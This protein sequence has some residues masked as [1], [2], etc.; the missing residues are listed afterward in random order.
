MSKTPVVILDA[1]NSII[2]ARSATNEKSFRHGLY[3]L[4]DAEFSA[5]IQRAQ[6]EIPAG[7]IRVNG[8]AYAFGEDAERHGTVTRPRGAARYTHE[9]YGTLAAVALAQL[10]PSANGSVN[11]FGSHP[12]GDIAYNKDL[13]KAAIG[14]YHVEIGQAE[15]WYEVCGATTFDEPL[16][17]LMNR[18][19]T[20][21]G[22]YN[23]RWQFNGGDTL[24]IDIGGF[25][26]DLIA[27]KASGKLDYSIAIS[28]ELGIQEA[29]RN[30]ERAV[31]A[32]YHKLFKTSG[33][34]PEDRLRAALA[35]GILKAAGD[36]FNVSNE[37][38]ESV[39]ILLNRLA[40]AFNREAGGPARW[41]HIVL[42]GGG[43]AML[44]DRL[45]ADVL[46]HSSVAL[47][48][49]DRDT[50]FMANVRGGLKLWRMY[51]QL[52]VY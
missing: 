32:S 30:F 4:S 21:E 39:N 42:T 11:L 40:D 47:A 50:M 18:M 41:D 23:S 44:A 10:Y 22:S 46:N 2:K 15:R 35:S 29:E 37:A 25:T 27:I 52:G 17:G 9:Y 7:Y 34:L 43:S 49:D 33:R 20:E 3:A 45:I 1:G 51:E 5:I 8:A 19:L 26:T 14:H 31:R 48:D 36:E 12:P 28:L 13:C 24:V 6:G 16:G 38:A